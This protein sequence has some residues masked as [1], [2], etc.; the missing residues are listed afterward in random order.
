M[1]WLVTRGS[2][3]G[4][5]GANTAGT[6]AERH[7]G[8]GAATGAGDFRTDSSTGGAAGAESAVISARVSNA[9]VAA[10]AA[11]VA[12]AAGWKNRFMSRCLAS[13]AASLLFFGL[14][15][16]FP[17]PPSLS[18]ASFSA[19]T[20]GSSFAGG[21]ARAASGGARFALRLKNARNPATDASK[22]AHFR[23]AGLSHLGRFRTSASFAPCAYLS[24]TSSTAPW[25]FLCLKHLPTAWLSARNACC[26]YHWS[27]DKTP[28][29][30]LAFF[31]SLYL[32][33]SSTCLSFRLG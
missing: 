11:A 5:G 32:R 3:A 15:P 14:P 26:E 16:P 19:P 20:E 23:V 2:G 33:L 4:R 12:A 31:S 17:P 1:S 6:G 8:G 22:S 13:A 28:A 18:F 30:F 27:P 25:S 21:G 24:S 9:S 10:A 7:R 29:R